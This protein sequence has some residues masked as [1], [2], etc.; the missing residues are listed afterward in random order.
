MVTRPSDNQKKNLP[1]N[2]DA[3]N[4]AF[5]E[6]RPVRFFQSG[7]TAAAVVF[8]LYLTSLYS[9]NLFHSLAEL[10]S[11]VVAWIIFVIAWK[12]RRLLDNDYLLLLGISYLFV[13]GLDLLH[14]L[15]YKGM[16][17]FYGFGANLPTQLWIASRYLQGISF[18]L[19][20]FFV[21][22]KLNEKRMLAAYIAATALIICS[23]FYWKIFPDCYT[24]ASG[25]TTFKKTSEYIISLLLL[26]SLLLLY[27]KRN[28]FDPAV[29]GLLALSL[30]LTVSSELMFTFYISV[31]GFSNLAG[32]FL[33]IF[34][35]YSIYKALIETGIVKPYSLIF[36]KLKLSEQSLKKAHDE[37]EMKVCERTLELKKLNEELEREIGERRKAEEEVR[38]LNEELEQRVRERTR[39]LEAANSELESFSYSVSHDLRAPLRSIDGFS[40]ALV[41]DY[42]G[43]LD[44]T[45]KDYLQRVSAAAGRMSDLIDHLLMLSR[46]SRAEIR[47]EDIDLSSVANSIKV[48]LLANNPE[49]RVDFIIPPRITGRGDPHLLRTVLE[50]L[51]GNAV[52][53][54]GGQPCARIEF[55]VFE[56][57][58]CPVY[59]VRDNGAG[60]DMGYADR[61][62]KPFQR[63]HRS[64]EFPGTG[65]GLST[66][67]RI[68][69]RHGGN[70][71]AESAPGKGTTFYFSIGRGL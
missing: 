31:Y 25:L 44:K 49:R 40:R 21:Y 5:A 36:R 65:I 28:A 33:K 10:F 58:G 2:S 7:L 11:I 38:E 62:F 27:R 22:R 48:D 63:L 43:V 42:S 70:I 53:Y 6:V 57:R 45:G 60:F 37:L 32:H 67:Y 24:P 39:Q 19:A 12:S 4:P 30:L 61:L 54:T 52:K 47:F 59:F 16:G 66:V 20:T 14:T 18:V 9:Y 17:V 34:A 26:S 71:R 55:G 46:V 35:V 13:G 56:D 1:M 69:H 8:G 41:E 23:I 64:S 15:S 29:F 68:I 51:L 3:N 50:N